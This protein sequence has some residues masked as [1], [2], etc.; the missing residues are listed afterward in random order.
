MW[1]LV[2]SQNNSAPQNFEVTPNFARYAITTIITDR[3]AVQQNGVLR[4]Q[5]IEC[6]EA[7]LNK[8]RYYH[9]RL[10]GA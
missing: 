2:G 8:F 1:A 9:V 7:F 3:Y 10:H 6:S 4:S 5:V